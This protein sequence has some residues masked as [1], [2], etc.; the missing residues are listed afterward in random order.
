MARLGHGE[1]RGVIP[2]VTALIKG[3]RTVAMICCCNKRGFGICAAETATHHRFTLGRRKHISSLQLMS[4]HIGRDYFKSRVTFNG[5]SAHFDFGGDRLHSQRGYIL[6]VLI[7]SDAVSV[8][9]IDI[10]YHR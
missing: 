10:K 4:V 2:R 3:I 9:I 6:I 8:F 1:K 7:M 5:Q